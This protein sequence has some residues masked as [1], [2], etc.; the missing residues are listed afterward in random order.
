MIW[1]IH[2]RKG[3]AATPMGFPD[4][5]DSEASPMGAQGESSLEKRGYPLQ[6][7]ESPLAEEPM[8]EAL[9]I[10]RSDT[11]AQLRAMTCAH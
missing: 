11:T 3:W 6:Y 8:V 9:A 10:T 4:G 1:K 5:S 7:S 2:G